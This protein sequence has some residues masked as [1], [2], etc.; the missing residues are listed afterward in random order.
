MF[1]NWAITLPSRYLYNMKKGINRIVEGVV[2][3]FLLNEAMT[4]IVYHFTHL[5]SVLNICKTNRIIL[6][7]C[8]TKPAD[9]MHKS[10]LF[11]LSTTRQFNG[12]QGYSRNHEVR[13]ELDGR[14]LNERFEGNAVNYWGTRETSEFEDRLYSKEP[15][16]D[17]ANKYIRN[18]S[19]LMKEDNEREYAALH[20]C[21]MLASQ[22]G[23]EISVFD[24]E[25]DFN[26]PR[27]TNII[28]NRILSMTNLPNVGPYN[29]GV[30]RNLKTVLENAMD[31]CVAF[32]NVRFEDVNEYVTDLMTKYD[33]QEHLDEHIIR[34]IKE[35]MGYYRYA[36][37]DIGLRLIKGCPEYLSVC[38]LLR[39][40]LQRNGVRNVREAEI[41]WKKDALGKSNMV[42][43]DLQKT[44]KILVFKEGY[45]RIPILKPDTTPFWSIFKTEDID[46]YKNNFIER[47]TYHGEYGVKSHKSRD[48]E[49][50]NKYVMHLV[51][52]NKITVS[53]MLNT[54]S[55]IDYY[56]D[57]LIGDIFYGKFIE[58]EVSYWDCW[59]YA[60]NPDDEKKLQELFRVK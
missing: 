8:I 23:I 49:Y 14:K 26:N 7:E 18:I 33:L 3:R 52:S 11:Y 29:N 16:I 54:L 28:N 40:V 50:F 38:Y 6:S 51:K 55:R 60:S 27:S 20:E 22:N 34:Y 17:D 2:N 25:R 44:I 21:L 4:D 43:Y 9:T 45:T 13:I 24:N 19:I 5:Y 58:E 10:K 48:E 37:P 35:K 15:Y 59:K 36:L 57:D 30:A 46:R 41:K 1:A 53:E 42:D 56:D 47:L 31:F 12:T 39:D 32:E